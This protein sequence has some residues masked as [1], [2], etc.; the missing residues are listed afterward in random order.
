M[1]RWPRPEGQNAGCMLLRARVP[2]HRERTVAF[3]QLLH[4][5]PHDLVHPD[6]NV[7]HEVGDVE[8]LKASI[9]AH[10][11]L[12]P[13]V[14]TKADDG[15]LE[16]LI[17]HR[18]RQAA[19]ELDLETVPCLVVD[20]Q[21]AAKRILK[22]L[23]ENVHRQGLTASEESDAYQQLVLLD[24]SVEQ[25]AAEAAKPVSRVRAA[26]ALQQLPDQAK[27]SAN[28]GQ[29]TFAQAA[30]LEKFADDPKALAKVIE[31]GS[32]DRHGGFAHAIA[33]ERDRRQRNEAAEKLRAQLVLDGVK[34]LP[35]PKDWHQGGPEVE[36][37]TLLDRDGNPVDPEAVKTRPGFAA[38]IE[39]RT[40]GG[41]TAVIFCIDPDYWGYTRTRPTS[42]VPDEE[43][44][45]RAAEQEAR[46]E[47]KAALATATGVRR[48]YLRQHYGVARNAKEVYLDALR[49]AIADPDS[50]A[51]NGEDLMKLVDGIAGA[52]LFS[53][54]HKAGID[55]LQRMLVGRWIA[56]A[57]QNLADICAGRHWRANPEA[58]VRYLDRLTAA[59]Y[60]LSD[61][62]QSLRN[63]LAAVDDGDSEDDEEEDDAEVSEDAATWTPE[64][65]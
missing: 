19:I 34:V 4:L 65:A 11:M 48:D 36:A 33:E 40:Y 38:F 15:Q 6:R 27:T 57:E 43:K 64:S 23:A 25:I 56:A 22:M 18:R 16:I 3:V 50:I 8:E 5:D 62:E 61:A 31:R 21:G 32:S 17:G 20:D 14:A 51:V 12:Q 2:S 13:L 7:R 60:L 28:T 49:D 35:K 30:E 47:H 63:D 58:G 41:P 52:A 45:R 53:T 55:R 44:R 1:R 29:L 9:H 54:V 37:S 39:K 10:G 42:F 24:M 26:L 46:E 59:G